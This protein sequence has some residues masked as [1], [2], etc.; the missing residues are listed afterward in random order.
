MFILLILIFVI[1]GVSG[2][3]I[4]LIYICCNDDESEL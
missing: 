2:G 4:Y 3:F 1:V